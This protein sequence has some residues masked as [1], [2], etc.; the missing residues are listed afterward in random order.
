M[1][2]RTI[3]SFGLAIT[4][5]MAGCHRNG[6][7][8]TDPVGSTTSGGRQQADP[9]PGTASLGE[10]TVPASDSTNPVVVFSAKSC[11]GGDMGS[12]VNVGKI[13]EDGIGVPPERPLAVKFYTKACEGG[14][15][16]G[17]FYLHKMNGQG[18]GAAVG[19][20]SSSPS[21]AEAKTTSVSSPAKQQYTLDKLAQ[22]LRNSDLNVQNAAISYVM[23]VQGT[24]RIPALIVA[25]RAP[26]SSIRSTAAYAFLE[27]KGKDERIVDPM[28]DMLDDPVD[29]LRKV[30][31]S[32]LGK[33]GHARAIAPL[34]RL[35]N[36]KDDEIR[37]AAGKSI[38]CITHKSQCE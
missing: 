25:A 32:V 29:N 26:D 7:G 31:I 22:D 1:N 35:L 8:A 12:C 21:N 23:N 24:E 38:E 5:G 11:N 18:E 36:D 3:G 6:G 14:H 37:S 28:I 13:Y 27:L 17:C 34:A 33:S 20:P 15:K 9:V 2:K 10:V 19:G 4:L 30:A 16:L